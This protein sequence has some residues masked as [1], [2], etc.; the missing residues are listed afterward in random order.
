[1][2]AKK[3]P[4]PGQLRILQVLWRR[5]PS[6]VRQVLEE[7]EREKPTHYT[8]VLKLMQIM[9]ERG[10]VTRDESGRSHVYSAA[11]GMDRTK[12]GLVDDLLERAFGGSAKSLVMH[13]LSGKRST[14][15]ELDEI[16]RYIDDMKR[17]KKGTR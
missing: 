14:P 1:M 17:R 12:Q 16:R 9:F 6:T 10:L 11:S 13:A 2:G 3:N 15:E 4:T 7:L 8:T 5:G